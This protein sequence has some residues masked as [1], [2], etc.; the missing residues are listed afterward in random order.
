MSYHPGLAAKSDTQFALF[1]P[2]LFFFF[3]FFPKPEM[4]LVC[5]AGL[6]IETSRV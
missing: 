6:Y 2:F 5:I 3:S 1:L 4:T